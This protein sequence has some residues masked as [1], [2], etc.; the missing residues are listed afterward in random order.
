V[1]WKKEGM[2]NDESSDKDDELPGDKLNPGIP[3]FPLPSD[4]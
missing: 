4:V 3:G 1:E 2:M